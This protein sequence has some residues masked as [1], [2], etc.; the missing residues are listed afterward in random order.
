MYK[1]SKL[2]TQKVIEICEKDKKEIALEIENMR[3]KIQE[4]LDNGNKKKK[5]EIAKLKRAEEKKI[6]EIKEEYKSILEKRVEEI[7]EENKALNEPHTRKL[8]ELYEKLKYLSDRQKSLTQSLQTEL[9]DKVRGV[10]GVSKNLVVRMRQFGDIHT[11]KEIDNLITRIKSEYETLEREKIFDIKVDY[12]GSGF[13][14]KRAP[15]ISDHA[16]TIQIVNTIDSQWYVDG[17][18]SN[19]DGKIAITGSTEDHKSRITLMDLTGMII[20]EKKFGK[21][22]FS[23][24]K[25]RF[26][27]FVTNSKIASVYQEEEI[28]IYDVADDSYMRITT[29]FKITCMA[30]DTVKD[31]IL[32]GSDETEVY[33]F[34]F[35]LVTRH[36]KLALPKII[37]GPRDISVN[38][39]GR[40]L[41]CDYEGSRIYETTLEGSES[42]A[43]YEFSRP[44]FDGEDWKPLCLCSDKY[45]CIFSLWMTGRKLGSGR[46]ILVQYGDNCRKLLTTKEIDRD[47][48]CATVIDQK[49]RG[50][51]LRATWKTGQLYSYDLI[52]EDPGQVG[53]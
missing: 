1:Y 17:I 45:K 30:V 8:T 27:D 35:Q 3:E 19:N 32:V 9:K 23:P 47:S 43:E 16:E 26:C 18:A 22:I 4:I 37:E 42:R 40:L 11:G 53:V 25:R 10:E 33:M 38:K 5:D 48:R 21:S 14:K 46:R 12:R 20:K 50:K 51:L 6:Q 13:R 34:D 7:D 24:G 39:N 36:R 44:D 49:D 2:E 15:S 52:Y 41:V 31:L 29:D 28:G